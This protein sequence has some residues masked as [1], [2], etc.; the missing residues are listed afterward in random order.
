MFDPHARQ[1]IEVRFPPCGV[2]VLESHHARGFQMPPVRH[3]FLKVVHPFS[4]AGWLVRTGARVPLRPGDVVLVPAGAR[5]HI[6]DEGGRPLALYALCLSPQ[7]FKSLPDSLARFRH[8]P[9]PVWSGEMRGLF[10][11]LLHEQTLARAGSDLMIAGLAWQALGHLARAAEGKAPSPPEH[12]D[13]PARA[14]V[15]AYAAD[16]ARTFYH[17]QSIGEA[18]T[19]LGLSRRHFTHLFKE[20]TGETWLEALHR[21]RLAHARRLLRETGR[22]ITSIGYEC[23]FDDLTTFYRA[24]KAATGSSPLAWR[25]SAIAGTTRLRPQRRKIDSTT[26][27]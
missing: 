17:R 20:T 22:S 1:P 13:H 8:F 19:A 9:E 14:R 2:F 18:A 7:A 26:P 25:T 10:R 21:H 24:F 3:D 27:N 5:H 23:G 12:A 4:G 6:E 15:A 16:L 11:H